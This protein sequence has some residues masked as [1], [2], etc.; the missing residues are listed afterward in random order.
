[1]AAYARA[2]VM[3]NSTVQIATVESTN[4]LTT[5]VFTPD[6]P[7]QQMRVLS[8]TDTI[9]DADTTTWT[10]QLVGIQDFGTGS[11]GA[12]LRAASGTILA[13]EFQ[14]RT[15]TGQDKITA[16]ILALDIPFGGEQGAWRTFDMTFPVQGQPTFAQST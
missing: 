6:Q 5:V 4:Q 16:N 8:P 10:C 2:H 13:V 12:A 1:M 7:V 14:P 3:R 11:L 9:T 15:G